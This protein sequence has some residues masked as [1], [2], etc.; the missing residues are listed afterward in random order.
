MA[1]CPTFAD[2]FQLARNEMLARSSLLARQTVDRDG[3]DANVLVAAATAAADEVIGQLI[4]VTAGLYIDT[5]TDT[6]LDRLLFDRYGLARKVAASGTTSLVFS[7]TA[8]AVATFTIPANT[9][10]TTAD[11]IQYETVQP[12]TFVIGTTFTYAIAKSILSG[13]NQQVKPATLTNIT[14]SISGAPTD[15]VVTN[16][17][18]S[19][20]AADVESD[21]A[22][23]ERGRAFFTTARRGTLR[24]IEQGALSVP[25]VVRATAFEVLDLSGRPARFVVVVIADEYTDTLASLSTLPPTYATQ[26]R[27]LSQT[28]FNALQDYR[29]G[30]IFVQVQVAQVIMLPV[31]LSLSFIAGVDID[32][33]ALSARSA[34]VGYINALNP[35]DDIDPANLV[36]ALRSINGLF[37]TGNEIVSPP[38]RIVVNP[39]QVYRTT[40]SIVSATNSSPGT[41]IGAY[42]NPDQTGLA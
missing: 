12:E 25:G 35:G 42:S 24:A 37:I 13:A 32:S 5:A 34:I 6:A 16:P 7:T 38:G 8:P 19:T 4:N 23:R 30:G 17:L 9:I 39:L 40:L 20:G 33:V 18:A 36:T 22:Y 11:G 3:S 26:S 1:D 27:A 2:L 15:L 14:G 28:V 21:D 41:P 31:Q 10:V 29:A